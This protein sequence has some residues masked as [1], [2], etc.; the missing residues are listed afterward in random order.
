MFFISLLRLTCILCVR[1][2]TF[3]SYGFLKHVV[4]S[5]TDIG[6]V[7]TSCEFIVD[8]ILVGR[9]IDVIFLVVVVGQ[10]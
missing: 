10:K 2:L 3:L 9:F 6:L 1:L 8:A 7:Y 5:V 4:S